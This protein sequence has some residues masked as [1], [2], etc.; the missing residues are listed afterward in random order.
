MLSGAIHFS[1]RKVCG[2]AGLSEGEEGPSP[3]LH[4]AGG[5]GGGEGGTGERMGETWQFPPSS[6]SSLV[7]AGTQFPCPSQCWPE[8]QE[9][10]FLFPQLRSWSPQRLRLLTEQASFLTWRAPD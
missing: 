5:W 8:G 10:E 2:R 7:P 1:G 3:T 4:L 9:A 6:S